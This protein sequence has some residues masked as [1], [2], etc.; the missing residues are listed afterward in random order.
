M[1]QAASHA[2]VAAADL[3]PPLA[4]G[5]SGLE[6]ELGESPQ[7]IKMLGSTRFMKTILCKQPHEGQLVLHV[8]MR[9]VSM[10][11]DVTQQIA[12]LRGLY[13]LLGSAKHVLSHVRIISDDR[14]VYILRQ[15]LHNNLYDRIST[16]P[17]LS[18]T[19]KRWMAYQMLVALR[20]THGRGV[21]HG[22]IKA[23]NIVVTSWN[24]AYLADFAPF[25]PTYLPADDPA[26][27][28]FYFDSA[29]RQCCCIAPERFYDPGSTI[30]QL[31][32]APKGNGGSTSGLLALQPSMDIF[33]V[34][35]V[36]AEL[37]LDG[38][39]L[40]S[41]S[42]L[43]QYRSK[44]GDRPVATMTD[45]LVSG[46]ADK[47]MAALVQHMVQLDPEARLSAGEYLDRWAGIFPRAPLAAYMDKE[48]PDARMQALHAEISSEAVVS[49]SMCEIT[50]S[51]A[52][53]N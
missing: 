25:K 22:D 16:R 15:Y 3:Q 11:F 5:V 38:N 6:T 29:G 20:E 7:H 43:L 37:F 32:A 4:M 24:L 49:D 23:E 48:S 34:G 35:C 26:E 39:P 45:S 12:T 36:I 17:F 21:C 28:N 33:S 50:A 41:L 8:F 2:L 14:A 40:F 27:F 31:L 1:G 13:S 53:A 46:I 44:Q 9:P 10:T 47:E 19:E 51:V 18:Q 52:C 42:R 30:A